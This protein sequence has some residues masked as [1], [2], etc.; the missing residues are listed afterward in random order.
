[1]TLSVMLPEDNRSNIQST[2]KW[3][4]CLFTEV[5]AVCRRMQEIQ[6]PY[7]RKYLLTNFH[8][9]STRLLCLGALYQGLTAL[10]DSIAVL[11]WGCLAIRGISLGCILLMLFQYSNF[12]YLS[13][14]P[15]P[16]TVYYAC[17]SACITCLIPHLLEQ[18]LTAMPIITDF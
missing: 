16:F 4:H 18:P 14:F 11:H 13:F 1:M 9:C 8:V 7:N 15:S 17:V 10:S 3:C 6:V 5:V 12:C 2:T